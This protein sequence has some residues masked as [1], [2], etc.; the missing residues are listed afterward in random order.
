[1]NETKSLKNYPNIDKDFWNQV[2]RD[3]AEINTAPQ[4]ARE[5]PQ[6]K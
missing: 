1:M 4:Q 5:P 6:G 2:K 3:M